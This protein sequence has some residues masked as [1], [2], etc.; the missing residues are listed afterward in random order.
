MAKRKK[1]G[2]AE[3]PSV[4]ATDIP[5][6][7]EVRRELKLKI[8]RSSGTVNRIL[9][10]LND[11]P[12]VAENGSKGSWKGTVPGV[13]RLETVVYG[14]GSAKYKLT[15]DLPGTAEDQSLECSL[16]NGYHNAEYKL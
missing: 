10:W 3:Q 8:E 11:Y 1:D 9:A 15:I 4:F 16:T 6:I 12:V 14:Q 13:V 7:P 5:V 2:A